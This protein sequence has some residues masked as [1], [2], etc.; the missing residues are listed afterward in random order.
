[1]L[2]GMHLTVNRVFGTVGPLAQLILNVLCDLS[3]QTQG[4]RVPH[5]RAYTDNYVYLAA[6]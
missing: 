1:M 2:N 5:A 3:G 6:K 4:L